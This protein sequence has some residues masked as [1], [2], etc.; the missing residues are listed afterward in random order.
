MTNFYFKNHFKNLVVIASSGLRLRPY[1][2]LFIFFEK[3]PLRDIVQGESGSS[4]FRLW[5]R[6]GTQNLTF[7]HLTPIR[8]DSTFIGSDLLNYRCSHGI[9]RFTLGSVLK[10]SKIFIPLYYKNTEKEYGGVV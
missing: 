4:H 10:T 5:G 3:C 8:N 2:P 9:F 7:S 6:E 1:K